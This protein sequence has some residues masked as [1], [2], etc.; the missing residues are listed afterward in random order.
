MFFDEFFILFRV[1]EIIINVFICFNVLGGML[2]ILNF[3]KSVSSLLIRNRTW[4]VG[5]INNHLTFI[6]HS[7][8]ARRIL[9]MELS[10]LQCLSWD[11]ALDLCTKYWKTN[12][13]FYHLFC[14]N[15]NALY[16]LKTR[17]ERSNLCISSFEE[18]LNNPPIQVVELQGEYCCL[19]QLKG[20]S[21]TCIFYDF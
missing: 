14:Y 9:E 18:Q 21:Y 11:I 16:L 17:K 1:I 20:V 13:D 2:M 6:W 8:T 3:F 12:I 7:Q 15:A 19:V 10:A 5:L 4:V